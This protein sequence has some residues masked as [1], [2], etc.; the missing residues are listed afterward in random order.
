MPRSRYFHKILKGRRYGGY[1]RT[2]NEIAVQLLPIFI[3]RTMEPH[4]N[5]GLIDIWKILSIYRYLRV[6]YEPDDK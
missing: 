2:Q 1:N 6:Q 3:F 5:Q 4:N